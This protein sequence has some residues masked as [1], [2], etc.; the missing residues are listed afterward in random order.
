M[1]L[2]LNEKNWRLVYAINKQ[3]NIFQ[4]KY[5]EDLSNENVTPQESTYSQKKYKHSAHVYRIGYL[6]K[7]ERI[8]E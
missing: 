4:D 2:T 1:E 8:S 6:D 5:V 3:L 7:K